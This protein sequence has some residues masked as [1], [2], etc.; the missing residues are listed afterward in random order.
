VSLTGKDYIIE[1]YKHSGMVNTKFKY[2]L[3]SSSFAQNV[4]LSF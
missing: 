2:R 4:T 3:E 1:V